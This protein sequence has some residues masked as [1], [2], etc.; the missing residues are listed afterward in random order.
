MRSLA[1]TGKVLSSR[2]KPPLEVGE[3][4]WKSN[5]EVNII[6]TSKEKNQMKI[7]RLATCFFEQVTSF[8][9]TQHLNLTSLI[10]PVFLFFCAKLQSQIVDKNAWLLLKFL[11]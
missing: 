1:E 6:L 2:E 3:C 8:L 9:P 10:W 5:L 7:K 4:H 11:L